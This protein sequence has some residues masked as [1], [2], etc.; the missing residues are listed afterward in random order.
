MRRTWL[1]ACAL[2][3]ACNDPGAPDESARTHALRQAEVQGIAAADMP[4]LE[5]VAATRGE[6]AT[7]QRFT[8]VIDGMPVYHQEL[9]MLVRD[10]GSLVTSTGRLFSRRTRRAKPHF[11]DDEAGAIQRAI[12]V[13]YGDRAMQLGKARARKMWVVSPSGGDELIAAWVVEA[14]TSE[15]GSTSG[16]LRRTILRDDGRVISDESLVADAAFSYLV[17]ADTT[18]EKHP[19]DGPTADATPHPTGT[20]DG[21]YPAYV[22]PSVVSVDSLS[23]SGD[24]WLAADATTTSGNN[25]DAYAD[26]SAPNGLGSGD[27][28]ATANGTAFDHSYDTSKG[29]LV[30]TDQQMASITSLFYTINWL[31]DFWYDAGFD[32][33]AGNAQSSNYGRGGVEDDVFLAEAQ[34]NA[35]GGSRNNA[36]MSTPDDG[37]S[38]RMQVYLWSGRDTR[39]LTL[40]PSGRTPVIGGAVFGPKN[41]TVTGTVVGGADTGE[42]LTDGCQALTNNV[43]GQIVLVDRGNCTFRTK[44]LNAQHAGAI[45]VIIANNVSGDIPPGLGDDNSLTETVTIPSVSVTQTEGAAIRADLVAGTVTATLHRDVAPELDGALDSTL[46][47]HE[48]GHYLHHRLAFCGNA[49]CRAMSE[50]W[51]D[52][53]A[54]MLLARPGDNLLGAYPFSVYATQGYAGDPGYYGIR[55]APYSAHT[56]I[57]ALS[58]RHMADNEP[59]PTTHPIQPSNNNA[60]VHNAGEVWAEVLWEAYVALQQQGGGTFE[61]IRAKMARY[62]VSGLSM[63][64]VEA[65]PMEARD[66]ILAAALAASPVDHQTLI[67][68]FARRGFGSCAV[69]P[70]RSSIDFFGI[71]ESTIV[72]G[73]PKIANF[74]VT[75]E[76]DGDG[77]L[78]TGETARFR[79]RVANQGHAP[80]LEPTFTITS[81]LAGVTVLSPPVQLDHLDPFATTDLEIEVALEPGLGDAIAGDLSLQVT[82]VGGCEAVTR[83]PVAFRL[84]V[85]DLP[86][87]SAVD[88]FDANYSPWS[89]WTAAWSHDRRTSLDGIWHGIDLAVQADVSL[90]SPYLVASDT[91][92]IVMSF[93]HRYSFELG[94]QP[95]DG[96]V[97]EVSTDNGVTWVDVASLTTET[98]YTGTI[99]NESNNVLAGRLGFIGRS[100]S[101]P[102]YETVTLDLGTALAGKQFQV[103]FRIGTDGGTGADGWDIDNVA[104]EGI[105]GTPFPSQVADDGKCT[106]DVPYDPILSG[107]GGCC[108]SG[109]SGPP[110]SSALG[111][112]VLGLVLRRRRRRAR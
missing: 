23:A 65:T 94:T 1:P 86:E 110:A 31:H 39:T 101:W 33:E 6:G 21:S 73:N 25:V 24:P 100:A 97:V 32:E 69:A 54:L 80:L 76:C 26:L 45:A 60:E 29:P 28:R 47:A 9:R 111:L 57:N 107:G 44:T 90:T 71:V 78:D 13:H 36:N 48:F 85:D 7:A 20:P 88:T 19:A 112:A 17:W 109:R 105:V 35:L 62:V 30:D 38:P 63:T 4:V 75:D 106:P 98:G 22:A 43:S 37:M 108:E 46:V 81:R 104:F 93:S 102:D 59:L 16:D 40:Q 79:I 89:P 103:R 2:I 68:A 72:A 53:V 64:P 11:V 96:G 82:S 50:G 74:A 61:E 49:M 84:N 66:A 58:F 70:D 56:N 83:I 95:W 87:S 67:A 5:P 77:I 52:F 18:G 41:F 51:G 14:Y 99:T 27:F 34:D 55:R 12:R 3:A 15:P 91:K 92:P 8:Q 10:D 42:S